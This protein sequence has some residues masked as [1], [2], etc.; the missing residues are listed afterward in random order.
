MFWF[1]IILGGWCTLEGS[2]SI[3][4]PRWTVRMAGLFSQ[5][6]KQLMEAQPTKTIRT[7][8]LME[9]IFGLWMLLLTRV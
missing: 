6:V 5:Q 9:L 7:I 1:L 4:F 2:C 8:G 3:L